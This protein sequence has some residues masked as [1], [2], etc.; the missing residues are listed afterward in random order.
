MKAVRK[1]FRPSIVAENGDPIPYI[2]VGDEH[3]VVCM[4]PHSTRVYAT[5]RH[6]GYRKYYPTI[7]V[8]G[9]TAYQIFLHQPIVSLRLRSFPR[10][11]LDLL[12]FKCHS[13]SDA[14]ECLE[15]LL[16][17]HGII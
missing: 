7:Y 10:C 14:I 4:N 8:S 17:H 2:W 1:L 13:M 9:F 3:R 6:D 15:E 16:G 12:R 5:L 11:A